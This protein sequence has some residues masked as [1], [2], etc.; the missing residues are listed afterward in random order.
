MRLLRPKQVAK[1]TGLGYQYVLSLLASGVLPAVRLP[2]RAFDLVDAADVER[3]IEKAK[4]GLVVVADPAETLE[5]H[6]RSHQRIRPAE[7][8]GLGFYDTPEQTASKPIE[9]QSGR[10]RKRS[11]GSFERQPDWVEEFAALAARRRR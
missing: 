3:L 8:R 9:V 5:Y 7:E 6:L 1:E 4:D 10:T 2:G 11:G